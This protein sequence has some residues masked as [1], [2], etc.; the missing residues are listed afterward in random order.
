[1]KGGTQKGYETHEEALS[2][3]EEAL[4]LGAVEIL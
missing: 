3:W 1:M 2:D 4:E